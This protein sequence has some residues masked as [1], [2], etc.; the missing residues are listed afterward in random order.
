MPPLRGLPP[1]TRYSTLSPLS[2]A[3]HVSQLTAAARGLLAGRDLR[4]PAPN[5]AD[6]RDL[7]LITGNVTAIPE[8]GRSA[9]G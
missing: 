3:E 2:S 7:V 6:L 8:P 1:P 9:L 5:L 4:A